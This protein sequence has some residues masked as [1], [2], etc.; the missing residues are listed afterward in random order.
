MKTKL[1][2]CLSFLIL[3]IIF[4]VTILNNKPRLIT[5]DVGQGD[6][7]ILIYKSLQLVIDVGPDNGKMGECLSRHLPFWDKNIEASI[8]SH[9]D[10][11]HSGSWGRV[12]KSYKIENVFSNYDGC[13]QVDQINCTKI[14]TVNDVVK[15]G[16]IE[17]EVLSSGENSEKD[18]D[19]N[20]GSIMGIL[21]YKDKHILFGGD[22][23]AKTEQRLVWRGVLKNKVDVFKVSHHGSQTATSEELLEVIRPEVAIISVGKGNRF[24]HPNREVLNRLTKYGSRIERT[25]ISG[26]IIVS[27]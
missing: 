1:I 23:T 14:L 20:E 2:L 12:V 27:L 8:L 25:D 4:W 17:F 21:K 18:N 16:M 19:N 22:V 9:S 15:V 26:D 6:G 13:S 24:G 7:A 3:I 10:K 5:C 11:D